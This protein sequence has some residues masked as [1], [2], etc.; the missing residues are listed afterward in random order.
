MRKRFDPTRRAAILKSCNYGCEMCGIP[1]RI[2]DRRMNIHHIT[3]ERL[4]RERRS[5]VLALCPRCHGIR[6]QRMI[7][8]GNWLAQSDDPIPSIR[9]VAYHQGLTFTES[10]IAVERAIMEIE[11]IKVLS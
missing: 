5:D 8:L 7:L 6:H 2:P 3:Y 4:G 9:E 1:Q 11:K 10:R